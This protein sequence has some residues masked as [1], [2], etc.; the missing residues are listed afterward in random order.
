MCSTV[1]RA[2]RIRVGEQASDLVDGRRGQ[3]V[4]VVVAGGAP[5]AARNTPIWQLS[6]LPLVV[7]YCL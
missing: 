1:C 2:A 7:V 3:A 6:A 5:F 4:A